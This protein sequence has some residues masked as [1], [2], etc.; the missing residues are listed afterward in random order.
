MTTPKEDPEAARIGQEWA[1]ALGQLS[2]QD[3][4]L[5]TLLRLMGEVVEDHVR[6]HIVDPDGKPSSR[7]AQSAQELIDVLKPYLR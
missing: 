4:R 3:E 6:F 1:H 2:E 7:K 5:L